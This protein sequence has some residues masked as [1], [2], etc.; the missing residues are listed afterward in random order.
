MEEV[1]CE[2]TLVGIFVRGFSSGL[3]LSEIR[4]TF[5]THWKDLH[6]LEVLANFNSIL[7]VNH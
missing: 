4:T 3:E 7:S 6:N 2:R 1:D 5:D